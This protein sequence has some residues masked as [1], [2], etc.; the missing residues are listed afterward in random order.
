MDKSIVYP[1]RGCP[2]ALTARMVDESVVKDNEVL[3]GF[4]L[5]YLVD[6]LDL[7]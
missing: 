4:M 6:Y 7:I 5:M 2:E 3:I 1:V